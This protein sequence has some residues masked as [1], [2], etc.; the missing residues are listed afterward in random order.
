MLFEHVDELEQEKLAQL[1]HSKS[2]MT[3]FVIFLRF[4]LLDTLE[5][6]LFVQLCDC[7]S[8]RQPFFAHSTETSDFS[9]G[10]SSN[11]LDQFT[12]ARK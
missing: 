11:I 5:N 4:W 7:A 12:I 2:D 6:V 9:V 1:Q 8:G 10:I 3:W